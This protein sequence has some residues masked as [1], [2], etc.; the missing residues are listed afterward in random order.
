MI[1]YI[2]NIKK[3]EK[4]KLNS[5]SSRLKLSNYVCFYSALYVVNIISS[6]SK[7]LTPTCR[8]FGIPLASFQNDVDEASGTCKIR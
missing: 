3:K 5:D 7:E 4:L 6:V 8:V 1:I 2:G